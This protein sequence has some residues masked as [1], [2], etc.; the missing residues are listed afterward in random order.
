MKPR[1]F[2][3]RDLGWCV[4]HHGMLCSGY[5]SWREALEHLSRSGNPY[6][7]KDQGN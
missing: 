6:V 3:H 2:R 5:E 7:K 1:I 4:H